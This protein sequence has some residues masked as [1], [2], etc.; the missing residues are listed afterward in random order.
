MGEWVNVDTC[1]R[2]SVAAI[3]QSGCQR[4][5]AI[6]TKA[7]REG[8]QS[9]NYF[10]SRHEHLLAHMCHEIADRQVA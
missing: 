9:V 4:K 7:L 8:E 3:C 2:S 6:Y 1:K 5:F 10:A